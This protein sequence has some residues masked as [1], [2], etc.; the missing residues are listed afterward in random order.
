MPRAERRGHLSDAAGTNELV[1]RMADDAWLSTGRRGPQAQ[2]APQRD[3]AGA[4]LSAARNGWR[5]AGRSG[6]GRGHP[7]TARGRQG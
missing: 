4:A 3:A 7:S 6:P 2:R 1:E 5:G